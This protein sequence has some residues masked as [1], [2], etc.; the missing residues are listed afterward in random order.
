M[1]P[2][3]GDGL[4]LDVLELLED[5]VGVVDEALGVNA[6]AVEAFVFVT[7]SLGVSGGVVGFR[8]FDVEILGNLLHVA[9]A[10]HVVFDGGSSVNAPEEAGVH[11]GELDLECADR[12]KAFG[13]GGGEFG[14]GLHFFG[15][16]Y[17][18]LPGESVTDGVEGTA[19]LA[20]FG[21]GAS[22]LLCV[23]AVRFELLIGCHI[24][25]LPYPEIAS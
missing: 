23:A 24:Y 20:S 2:S 3:R 18:D 6:N 19:A 22:A 21:G 11:G 5:L 8:V 1:F 17:D 9:Q 7:E 14:V 13:Y 10:E 15:G 25:V 4:G 16:E 12:F